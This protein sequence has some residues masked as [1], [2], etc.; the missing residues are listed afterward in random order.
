MPPNGS[1]PLPPGAVLAKIGTDLQAARQGDKDVAAVLAEHLL[2][3]APSDNAVAL[4]KVA[5]VRLAEQR[6]AHPEISDGVADIR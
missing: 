2:I 4:A 6:A 3:A 1:Q 5:L